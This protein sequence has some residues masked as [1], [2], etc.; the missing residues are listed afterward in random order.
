MIAATQVNH[1]AL[2]A[3]GVLVAITLGVT[4][5][6]A[7]RTRTTS[8]FL[9]AGGRIS[10]AQ[11]GIAISGDFMSAAT[12]L[13]VTGLVFLVGIEGWTV[14][15]AAVV[16]I[17]LM[18][19]LFAERMRNAGEYT[20]AD[21]LAF[22]LREGPAR[23]AAASA[24]L[25]VALLFLVAQLVG[26]GVLLGALAGTSFTLSV[27]I[28]GVFMLLYVVF[29]GMLATTW[30]QI[31]K[32]VLLI[33]CGVGLTAWVL[34]RAGFDPTAVITGAAD[35]HPAGHAILSPGLAGTT[36]PN[37]I[38]GALAFTLGSAALPHILVRFF[39]VRDA[40]AAR[41]SMGWAIALIGGFF[42]LLVLLG[43]ATRYVLGTSPEAV[44]ATKSG[45]NLAVPLMAEVL[46]GGPGTTAGDLLLAVVSAVAFATILAVVSGVVI[47]ASGAVAHDLWTKLLRG[48][49]AS[50]REETIAARVGAAGV[51]TI[52]VVLAMMAGSGFNVAFLVGLALSVS[53]AANFPAL[54]LSFTWR[55]FTT[56]GAVAGVAV[57]LLA[58]LT[59]IVLSPPVWPGADGNGSP[60]ALTNPT[61][62]AVPLGFAACWLGSVLSSRHEPKAERGY[63]EMLF[64]SLTGYVAP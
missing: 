46:G 8:E 40:P 47:S 41:R 59:C 1:T 36:G 37:V 12:F 25:F 30:V 35:R 31:I 43:F 22:R 32:A 33:V 48:G 21:A 61:I 3:F 63:A 57:G 18:L 62:I 2:V 39:T 5:W 51:G 9:A 53:A 42:A 64:R 54:L 14:A 58:S 27:A 7:R 49:R 23:A 13:G 45:G 20:V 44:I 60:L 55:R 34:G 16:A 10:G 4:V 24:T 17:L 50:D 28:T 52:A 26:A 11:N 15:C 56:T 38:S 29:G 6:A 19:L